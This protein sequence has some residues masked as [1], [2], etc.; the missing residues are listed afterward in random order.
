MNVLIIC[1]NFNSYKELRRYIDSIDVAVKACPEINVKVVIGDNSSDYQ[2]F[3]YGNSSNLQILQQ[4][5]DNVGYMGA[6]QAILNPVDKKLY[7]YYIISNVDITMDSS[8]FT[9]LMNARISKDV[10]WIAPSIKSLLIGRDKNPSVLERYPKWKLVVLKYTYNRFVLPLYEK[11]YYNKKSTTVDKEMDIYAG[12]GSFF[13]LTSSFFE[14]YDKIDY[15]MFLYGEEL[16][17]AELIRSVNMK[18]RYIPSLLIYDYEHV[19]T[20]LIKRKTYYTY[21]K[22]ALNYILKRFY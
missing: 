11:V 7:D 14:K 3:V 12:H 16:Y 10:A 21:N 9:R 15:P 8:F 18:V 1:V 4:R 2:D 17:F 13:L 5:F 20:S 6:A 19:S 22:K